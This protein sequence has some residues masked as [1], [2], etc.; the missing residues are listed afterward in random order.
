MGTV[1]WVLL[2]VFLYSFK[3]TFY[4][5]ALR[6]G[7]IIILIADIATMAYLY[8]A[9]YGRFITNELDEDPSTTEWK[10][11]TKTQKY[12]RKNVYDKRVEDYEKRKAF[13]KYLDNLENENKKINVD[14]ITKSIVI[15]KNKIKA[16]QYIQKWWRKKHNKKHNEK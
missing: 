13:N 12:E 14:K 6:T 9:Y 2:W 16:C 5:E 15:N 1:C 3:N 8:K 4:Y 10:Y 11:D 7:F